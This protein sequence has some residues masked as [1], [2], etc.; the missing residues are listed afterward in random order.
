[1]KGD[2]IGYDRTFKVNKPMKIGIVP[3]G[4]ADG[5][6]RKLSNKFDVIISGKKHRIVGLICMDIFMVD[7]TNDDI[8]VGDKVTILGNSGGESISL[9]DM[10]D[11]VETSPYEIMCDFNYRRMNY[12]VKNNKNT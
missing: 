1:K 6:N 3:I 10:A 11:I 8:N 7:I 9:Q 12:I 4:Y 2:T 5:L